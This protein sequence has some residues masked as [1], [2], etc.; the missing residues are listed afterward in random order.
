MDLTRDFYFSHAYDLTN[1]L[2][3]NVSGAMNADSAASS[4]A[5]NTA[6]SSFEGVGSKSVRVSRPRP[7]D[8][9]I[10]NHHLAFN[11]FRRLS[12]SRWVPPLVHGFFLQLCATIFG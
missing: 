7:H 1:T 11:L 4:G 2:Q 3:A 8:R 10:W 12:T 6:R 5:V 9:F